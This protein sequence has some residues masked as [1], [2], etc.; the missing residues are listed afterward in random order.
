MNTDVEENA[1]L[2]AVPK[3]LGLDVKPC[4]LFCV[5]AMEGEALSGQGL[6]SRIKANFWAHL[7]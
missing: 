4:P 1:S 6:E 5:G 2:T 3:V 7:C